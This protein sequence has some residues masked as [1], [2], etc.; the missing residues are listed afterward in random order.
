MT[1]LLAL[2]LAGKSTNILQALKFRQIAVS[3]NLI[4]SETSKT[5]FNKD[6]PRLKGT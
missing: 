6:Q 3:N 1:A 2:I 4:W 5:S